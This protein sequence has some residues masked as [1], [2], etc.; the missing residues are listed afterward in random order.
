MSVDFSPP[1]DPHE[2]ALLA[3]AY[4]TLLE[5][6]EFDAVLSNVS[7]CARAHTGCKA[8]VL[9][10]DDESAPSQAIGGPWCAG[11]DAPFDPEVR[12]SLAMPVVT[13]GIATHVLH[14]YK[15][16]ADG[17]FTP[18]EI[19][20]ARRLASVAGLVLTGAKLGSELGRLSRIDDETGVLVRQGFEDDVVAA[21]DEHQGRVG[22]FIVRVSDLEQINR[23]WGRD[24]GDEMLRLVA[25]AMREA[26]KSAGTVG[27]LRRHEFG[28]LLPGS[29]FPTTQELAAQVRESLGSP[30]P[31]LGR[32]DVQARIAIGAAAA[33]GGTTSSI[34]PLLHATY[35]ALDTDERDRRHVPHVSPFSR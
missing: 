29:D 1:H 14:F 34:V 11:V 32:S 7:E 22:L 9:A 35:K 21:L 31:V 24:V 4:K 26:I 17:R 2:A 8:V 3:R 30:L 10:W 20:H 33:R 16:T 25:R 23:Q 13:D 28:A 12:S 15:G 6:Q 27:R 5:R 19:D 18:T